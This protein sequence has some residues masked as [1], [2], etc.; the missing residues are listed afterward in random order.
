MD[1]GVLVGD[2]LDLETELENIA[3]GFNQLQNIPSMPED[4]WPSST[5]PTFQNGSSVAF[6]LGQSTNDPFGDSFNP[7]TSANSHSV[8]Q[9]SQ[10]HSFQSTVPTQTSSW[11]NF[12]TQQQ[13][14]NS[15]FNNGAISNG[16]H[17]APVYYVS[18]DKKFP[19]RNIL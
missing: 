13:F 4:S 16:T 10:S 9:V 15:F 17:T 12:A 5:T 7:I 19:Q 1:G 14:N 3:Q 6:T 2:L 8:E 11:T 18:F